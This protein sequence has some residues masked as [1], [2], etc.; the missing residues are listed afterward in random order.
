MTYPSEENP[1][2]RRMQIEGIRRMTP[3]RKLQLA[4]QLNEMLSQLTLSQLRVDF[5]DANET[6]LRYRLALKR[7]VPPE[8]L[9]AATGFDATR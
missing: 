8:L 7:G 4:S 2:I 6:E 5:P 1:V 3:G 9:K